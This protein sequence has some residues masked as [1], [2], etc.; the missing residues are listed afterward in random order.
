M[1]PISRQEVILSSRRNRCISKLMVG[2]HRVIGSRL[3]PSRGDPD[4]I[5]ASDCFGCE[6]YFPSAASWDICGPTTVPTSQKCMASE[7]SLKNHIGIRMPIDENFSMKSSFVLILQQLSRSILILTLVC[8]SCFAADSGASSP[9]LP[10]RIVVPKLQAEIKIDGKLSESVWTKAAAVD[11]FFTNDAKG[12]GAE[13]TRVRL[14][15]DD[16]ALYIGWVCED[17]DIQATFTER[18]SKFW[19]EEVAEFFITSGKLERYFEL[20]WNPL[21]GVFDAIIMNTLDEAGLSK[22]FE[23]DWSFTAKDMKSAV[24]VVGT[25]QK[26]DDK[27]QKWVVEVVVPFANL[28]EA[29]PKKGDVW[30]GNF[31]RFNRTRGKQPELLSWSPTRLSSF[32]EPSRFGYIEFGGPAQPN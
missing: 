31:Y 30:R 18:D 7:E 14:W 20:Q 4:Q 3:V 32:H 1:Q 15:Y 26:S 10:R 5:D 6:E 28:N 8:G 25:V 23:G 22:T 11:P 19:E 2:L 16:T 13:A 12:E 29:P 9:M 17:T 21:G 27:D 24:T